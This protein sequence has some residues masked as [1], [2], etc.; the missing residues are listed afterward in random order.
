MWWSSY[1]L[2]LSFFLFFFIIFI[3]EFTLLDANEY[4]FVGTSL[5]L[6]VCYNVLNV[7]SVLP[8][9][10][11]E[12]SELGI[13]L[14][15]LLKGALSFHD[16]IAHEGANLDGWEVLWELFNWNTIE[17]NENVTNCAWLS[18]KR[19]QS[20]LHFTSFSGRLLYK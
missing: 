20:I 15:Q 9:P 8:G 18:H 1:A 11:P 2:S 12:V 17:V 16:Q 5:H 6:R 14:V 13:S 19:I 10:H 3:S 7:L 4:V